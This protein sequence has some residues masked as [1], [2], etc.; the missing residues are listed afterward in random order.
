MAGEP[1]AESDRLLAVV[2]CL[3]CDPSDLAETI[4]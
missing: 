3:A 1:Q 2:R 4:A